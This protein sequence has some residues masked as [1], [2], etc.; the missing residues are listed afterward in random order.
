L[1]YP[2]IINPPDLVP[3]TMYELDLATNIA[4]IRE[5]ASGP[6]PFVST[7]VDDEITYKVVSAPAWIVHNEADG[8]MVGTPDYVQALTDSIVVE[9][10]SSL[11]GAF[12]QQVIKGSHHINA[13]PV[14]LS[15]EVTEAEIH[16]RLSQT[17]LIFDPDSADGDFISGIEVIHKPD[18][19]NVKTGLH[20]SSVSIEGVP[21]SNDQGVD[22]LMVQVT[23]GVG[24]ITTG[25][26][27]IRVFG[28]AELHGGDE[29]VRCPGDSAWVTVEYSGAGPWGFQVTD[30]RD[31]L[32]VDH[33]MGHKYTFGH[34]MQRDITFR[35]VSLTTLSG[36]LVVVGNDSVSLRA[37]I[38]EVEKNQT[39]HAVVGETFSAEIQ[40][41][42]P[43]NR[44]IL[45]EMLMGPSWLR[46]E[47][48]T[49]VSIGPVPHDG[50]SEVRVIVESYD[51]LGNAS[52]DTV[53]IRVYP[54]P[55]GTVTCT[56]P[57]G[58]Y[59]PSELVPITVTYF[60]S[61][62]WGFT[63]V[64]GEDTLQRRGLLE[65]VYTDYIVAGSGVVKLISLQA[66]SK[67]FD[68]DIV[69]ALLELNEP[70]FGE[71]FPD[72]IS[73]EDY[74][75]AEISAESNCPET[76]HV[77]LIEGPPWL[78]VIEENKLSGTPTLG[79]VGLTQVVLQACDTFGNCYKLK[80]VLLVSETSYEG[81]QLVSPNPFTTYVRI[82]YLTSRS[83]SKVDVQ[84]F[85]LEAKHV[86]ANTWIE[87]EEG[88]HE[89]VWQPSLLERG[90]YFIRMTIRSGKKGGILTTARVIKVE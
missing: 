81:I 79:D 64:N 63:V 89:F 36:S 90:Y 68:I 16:A 27:K 83:N 82:T 51:E 21:G 42:N 65:P 58:P 74:F 28:F 26:L 78:S 39:F 80:N 54:H 35:L 77:E 62:P 72:A 43:C 50:I 25:K 60:D 69:P 23:D 7:S 85:N 56:V 53:L 71:I 11:T 31:T 33:L 38:F 45:Q 70:S 66:F 18:W 3:N 2:S 47:E 30:G 59:W 86:L 76:Y 75:E 6:Y 19:L 55:S 37:R 41:D 14:L 9:F 8:K 15:P 52:K 4:T 17:L 20:N 46:L 49:I 44:E 10:R 57:R 61:F 88:R 29:Y 22:S 48:G 5:M 34:E 84:V 24:S 67:S 1:P 40:T 32:T 73:V 12:C 13:P 87:K